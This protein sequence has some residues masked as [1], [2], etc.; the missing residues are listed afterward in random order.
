M[1][2]NKNDKNIFSDFENANSNIKIAK[3]RSVLNNNNLLQK[4][5]KK[6]KLAQAL[7]ANLTRRK[8]D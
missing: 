6:K 5:L 2:K 1:S 8:A 3:L 4:N 7:R